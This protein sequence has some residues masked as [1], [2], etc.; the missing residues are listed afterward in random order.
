MKNQSIRLKTVF[1]ACMLQLNIY[2]G[3]ATTAPPNGSNSSGK[4]SSIR[5]LK[6]IS[7]AAARM[8]LLH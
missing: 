5:A 2:G 8:L 7:K 1:I 6:E 3:S 4:T